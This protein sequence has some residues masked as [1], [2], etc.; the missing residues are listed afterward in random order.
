MIEV[1]FFARLR[2]ELGTASMQIDEQ[3]MSLSQL[4]SMLAAKNS[5]WHTAFAKD[6]LVAVNQDMVSEDILLN[7]GD[8]VAYFPPVTGG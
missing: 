5:A 1:V 3:T 8:E 7:D 4:T 2:E 6:L